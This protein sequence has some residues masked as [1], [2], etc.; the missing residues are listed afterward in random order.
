MLFF[1]FKKVHKLSLHAFTHHYSNHCGAET[2]ILNNVT[3]NFIKGVILIEV[4]EK[5]GALVAHLVECV[6]H[7][8]RP[9]VLTAATWI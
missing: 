1:L 4:V 6:S 8:S 5:W 2:E 7:V 9:R 3:S